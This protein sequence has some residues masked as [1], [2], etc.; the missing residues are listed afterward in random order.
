MKLVCHLVIVVLSFFA[1]TSRS[2]GQ[3]QNKDTGMAA[4]TISAYAK[5]AS[6]IGISSDSK[7]VEVLQTNST[8]AGLVKVNLHS[9]DTADLVKQTP[10]GTLFLNRIE[11]FVRFSGFEQ[12]TA[13]VLITVMSVDDPIFGQALRE[14]ESAVAPHRIF[15]EHIVEVQGVKSCD[16][17]VRYIGFLIDDDVAT[18][19]AKTTLQAVLKYEITH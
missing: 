9:P 5:P 3:E 18:A 1:F 4:L 13:T 14:G 7:N 8:T 17:I 10:D 2:Y 11:I 15:N 19:Q 6:I 16:R 12:E